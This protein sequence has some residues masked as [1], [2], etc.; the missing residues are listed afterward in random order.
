[1][2]EILTNSI[3]LVTFNENFIDHLF[4]LV[5]LTRDEI[6]ESFNYTIIKF[7]TSLNEQ[8]MIKN[9]KNDLKSNLILNILIRRLGNSKTFGENLIFI[10]NRLSITNDDVC[11]K[12]LVLK[13]LFLLFT[14]IRT[15][16]YFY[17]NDLKVLIDV[18]LREIS[19]LP[20][21][22]EVLRNTYLRVLYPLLDNSQAKFGKYKIDEIFNMLLSLIKQTNYFDVSPTT[23]RLVKRCLS[24]DCFQ[25]KRGNDEN[26]YDDVDSMSSPN[27]I[28]LANGDDVSKFRNNIRAIHSTSDLLS[29]YS[30]NLKNVNISSD[31]ASLNNGIINNLNIT[32]KNN[33]DGNEIESPLSAPAST[34]QSHAN[35]YDEPRIPKN[36]N[37]YNNLRKLPPPPRPCRSSK[38]MKRPS[39]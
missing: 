16:D 25:E 5:E 9:L 12:L 26:F 6:D 20:D 2:I 15:Q 21:E 27:Q 29:G 14:T 31:I 19:D 37:S 34:T 23:L 33:N 10:L 11:F 4:D 24:C 17:T 22:F 39:N 35:L 3:R 32:N 7:L 30:H 8:Y 38:P 1:M 28:A 36:N 13:V 18:F